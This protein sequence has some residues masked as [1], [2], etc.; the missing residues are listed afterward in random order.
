VDLNTS[1]AH[2]KQGHDLHGVKSL[3][4]PPMLWSAEI[5]SFYR[6]QPEGV[7]EIELHDPADQKKFDLVLQ[8]IREKCGPQAAPP[9]TPEKEHELDFANEPI[10]CPGR[11]LLD[12]SNQT[13]RHFDRAILVKGVP[14]SPF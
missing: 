9:V 10:L 6:Y 4:S 5:P 8:E 14:Q 2:R 3:Y 7:A 12:D 13:F 1:V 11:R